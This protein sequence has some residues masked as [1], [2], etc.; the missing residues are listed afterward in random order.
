MKRARHASIAALA[1]VM[2]ACTFA[3]GC[4]YDDHWGYHHYRDHRYSYRDRDWHRDWR[5]DRDYDHRYSRADPF[6][7]HYND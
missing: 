7:D 5:Y 3:S 1:L 2:F 4:Y 6:K